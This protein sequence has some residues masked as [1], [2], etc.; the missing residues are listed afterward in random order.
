MLKKN[1]LCAV[2]EAEEDLLWGKTHLWM[3]IIKK[4]KR[5][6]VLKLIRK[7]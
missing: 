5:S 4:N 3:Q 7:R 6:V 1:L 2:Q